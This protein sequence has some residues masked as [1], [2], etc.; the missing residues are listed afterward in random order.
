MISETETCKVLS[1]WKLISL[2]VSNGKKKSAEKFDQHQATVLKNVAL[3]FQSAV[4]LAMT[5]A[6]VKGHKKQIADG[7]QAEA[8]PFHQ[9]CMKDF[10]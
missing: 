1:P 4:S 3:A 9:F 6:V 8:L 2:H 5:A 10:L 7:A